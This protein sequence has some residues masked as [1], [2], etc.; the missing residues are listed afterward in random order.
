MLPMKHIR[1]IG[2]DADDTLWHNESIFEKVHGRYRALLARYHDSDTVDKTLLATE[3][4]NL[5]LYGYGIKG[6]TLSAIE[7]AIELTEG[8]IGAEEISTLI[9]LG[10]E[11]LDHPVDLLDG[12]KETVAAL[13]SSHQLGLITK[14]DLRDQQRKLSKSGLAG[15]FQF[16]EIV[17]EKDATTYAQILERRR[18]APHEFLMIGN[19]MKSDILPVL[20]IGASALHIPYHLSWVLDRTEHVP[21]APGRFF[22]A[23]HFRELTSK[24]SR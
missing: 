4:R 1:V 23:H 6:F 16:I 10:R 11:M 2:L 14:G 8:K 24:L 3:Q 13:A 7:T 17:S 5:D 15:H 21:S 12:V 19:S 18:I 9:G 22:S 20:E